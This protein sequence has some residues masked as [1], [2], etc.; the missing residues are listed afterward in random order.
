MIFN[1][2]LHGFTRILAVGF[3]SDVFGFNSEPNKKLRLTPPLASQWA[4]KESWG[5][6]FGV[7][8]VERVERVERGSGGKF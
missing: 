1:H 4:G 2:G 5:L 3:D 7:D 8:R 6:G